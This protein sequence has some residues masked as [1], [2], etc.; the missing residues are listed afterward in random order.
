[1]TNTLDPRPD[2]DGGSRRLRDGDTRTIWVVLGLVAVVA[3]IALAFVLTQN[4]DAAHQAQ[5]DQA[6]AQQHALDASAAASASAN[7]AAAT[8][9]LAASAAGDAAARA[10]RSAAV[11]ASRNDAADEAPPASQPATSDTASTSQQ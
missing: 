3:I 6:A 5:L 2:L 11:G 4:S 9:G 8:A 10:Q 7:T 1:M